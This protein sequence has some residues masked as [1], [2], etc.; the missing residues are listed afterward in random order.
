MTES[1]AVEAYVDAIDAYNEVWIWCRA[2]SVGFAKAVL[3]PSI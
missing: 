1:D 3:N 2:F